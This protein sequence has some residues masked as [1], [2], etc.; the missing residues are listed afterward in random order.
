M[1]RTKHV[2]SES[3]LMARR[4]DEINKRALKSSVWKSLLLRLRC[5]FPLNNNG[6]IISRYVVVSSYLFK[7][8]ILRQ[9]VM[10]RKA[11][12][13]VKHYLTRLRIAFIHTPTSYHNEYTFHFNLSQSYLSLILVANELICEKRNEVNK[14]D[15]KRKTKT[16]HW[17]GTEF[18]CSL[19]LQNVKKIMLFE[20]RIKGG[21]RGDGGRK[22]MTSSTEK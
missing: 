3:S 2:E 17:R 11:L 6:G 15:W 22:R 20:E 21:V 4:D 1:T 5:N 9:S 19:H 16:W 14:L 18:G 10:Q 7:S 13:K 12:R 8:Y